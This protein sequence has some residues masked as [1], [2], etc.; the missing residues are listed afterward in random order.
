MKASPPP[1]GPLVTSPLKG[2]GLDDG[3]S[4]LAAYFTELELDRESRGLQS[5]RSCP[6]AADADRGPAPADT[7]GLMEQFSDLPH[8]LSWEGAGMEAAAH[9]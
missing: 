7:S 3:V 6:G 2:G 4:H 8:V 9:L 1:F 5:T